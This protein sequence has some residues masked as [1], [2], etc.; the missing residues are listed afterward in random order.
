MGCKSPSNIDVSFRLDSTTA[1]GA[2]SNA[3]P[4][5]AYP[6]VSATLMFK[7]PR[8]GRNEVRF[9]PVFVRAA[10]PEFRALMPDHDEIL[11]QELD[12][13]PTNL[14]VVNGV[15]FSGLRHSNAASTPIR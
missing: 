14:D 9:I 1:D 8:S 13:K 10:L 3:G 7:N 5:F 15:L 6:S 11:Q 4:H 2:Q 12:G